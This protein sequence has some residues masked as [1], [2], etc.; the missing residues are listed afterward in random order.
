MNPRIDHAYLRS[1]VAEGG[2]RWVG[3]QQEGRECL[4][5]FADPVNRNTISLRADDVSAETVRAKVQER[6]DKQIE[7]LTRL[8]P[9]VTEE[10]LV[11]QAEVR[12][13]THAFW[14]RQYTFERRVKNIFFGVVVLL[15]LLAVTVPIL[16]LIHAKWSPR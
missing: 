4:V 3:L 11:K 6:R 1:A 16:L 7:Y 15:L 13:A 2:A 10:Q 9:L 14:T 8:K 12:E 5:L